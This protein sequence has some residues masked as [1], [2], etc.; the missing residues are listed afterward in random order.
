MPPGEG[1][2]AGKYVSREKVYDCVQDVLDDLKEQPIMSSNGTRL[3][4]RKVASKADYYVDKMPRAECEN[5]VKKSRTGD[6]LIRQ[7]T[8]GTQYVLVVND[9]KAV[10]NFIIKKTPQGKFEMAGMPHD[11]LEMLL[12]YVAPPFIPRSSPATLKPA[13]VYCP[14][15]ARG[16][17]CNRL[18]HLL[19]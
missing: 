16:S 17:R 15:R 19:V 3:Y 9:N 1:A 4:L 18:L 2:F 8:A 10:L 5:F 6:Y 7:N 12:R 14:S 13:D 11:S